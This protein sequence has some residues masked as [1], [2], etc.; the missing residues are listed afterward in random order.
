MKERLEHLGRDQTVSQ[1]FVVVEAFLHESTVSVVGALE[2]WGGTGCG[3]NS[4]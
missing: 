4:S 2:N 1:T 3:K